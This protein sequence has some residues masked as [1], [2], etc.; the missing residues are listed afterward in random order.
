M[1][2]LGFGDS[3][4]QNTRATQESAHSQPRKFPRT[5]QIKTFSILQLIEHSILVVISR[6]PSCFCWGEAVTVWSSTW[7]VRTADMKLPCHLKEDHAERHLPQELVYRW[8]P[9]T[10]GGW[11]QGPPAGISS[12]ISN[13]VAYSARGLTSH[14]DKSDHTACSLS[15]RDVG[16]QTEGEEVMWGERNGADNLMPWWSFYMEN[17]K[18]SRSK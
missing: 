16:Q 1:R 15:Q 4:P 12:L 10:G 18:G 7:C 2:A 13:A 14:R 6:E 17:K 9:E 8:P 3:H 5:N 11:G